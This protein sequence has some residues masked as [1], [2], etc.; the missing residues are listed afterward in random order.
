MHIY[1]ASKKGKINIPQILDKEC[2][3]WD[4]RKLKTISVNLFIFFF[5]Y[6]DII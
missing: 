5:K 4:L 1:P 3:E 2:M 6:L